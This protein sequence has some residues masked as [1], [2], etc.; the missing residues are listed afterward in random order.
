MRRAS[1]GLACVLFASCL[2]GTILPAFG[3]QDPS[4]FGAQDPSFL[5]APHLSFRAPASL[6]QNGTIHPA[7][8]AQHPPLRAPTPLRQASTIHPADEWPPMLFSGVSSSDIGST[9]KYFG[10]AALAAGAVTALSSSSRDFHEAAAYATSGLALLAIATGIVGNAPY[11]DLGEG[12][13]LYNT[14]ALLGLIGGIG[15]VTATALGSDGKEH[16]GFGVAGEVAA[17]LSVAI[18]RWPASKS[19]S[20]SRITPAPR[21]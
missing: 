13:S 10:Y 5:G 14:H 15:F 17:G 19:S 21:P 11:I 7:F 4:F 3:E 9:H 12:F 20:G 6:S 16:S 2:A 18:L 8:A 1:V